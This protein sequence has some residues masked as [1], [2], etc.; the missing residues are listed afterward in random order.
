M[1]ES[2]SSTYQRVAAT[3][4]DFMMVDYTGVGLIRNLHAAL[5]QRQPGPVCMG[6]AEIIVSKVRQGGG[7]VLI[8]TGF[9]EGGGAPE[10]DGPVGAAMLARALFLG[11]RT[12]SVIVIDEDWEEM[13]IATARGA[14]LCP[15]PFPESG[16]IEPIE[17]LRPVYIRTVPKDDAACHRV[18]DELLDR[19]Q[20]SLMISIERPGENAKG[21]YHGL[22]GRPLD[23]LVADLDYLFRQGRSQG[24]PFIGIGDGG[25]E[26]G[27]GVVAD[28]LPSF[29][30]KAADTGIPGRGGVAAVNAAD[31]LVISNVSN[32]GATGVIASL[33]ALLENPT[34]FHEPELEIRSIE[35][36]VASGGVDG[37]F[38][39]PE[40]AVDGIPATEWEG[41]LRALRSSM[42]RT[43]GHS[44]NWQGD[45]G[46]W[47]QL[48]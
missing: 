35:A 19:T 42:L 48:K 12:E 7:P 38:M 33:A 44:V 24:I 4:D 11:L 40:P 21:L 47:R 36:C 28:A 20:P 31:W 45:S 46:D 8:A 41:L 29:S 15:M 43:L 13:M 18:S 5:Q 30:P 1:L 2:S 22:G 6:A 17:Y 32:W 25:N 23:G 34:V 14:G 27:M 9:P 16:K 26:L 37:M 3:I 10:T 39:A